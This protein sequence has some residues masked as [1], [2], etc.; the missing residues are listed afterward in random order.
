MEQTHTAD[1]QWELMMCFCV[2][3]YTYGGGE[4]QV[5]FTSVNSKN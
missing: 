2:Q 3:T 4:S 5:V 1:G